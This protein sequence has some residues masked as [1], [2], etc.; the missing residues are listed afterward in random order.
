MNPENHC[1]VKENNFSGAIVRVHVSFRECNPKISPHKFIKPMAS[2]RL[3]RHPS[4]VLGSLCQDFLQ[5]GLV[6]FSPSGPSQS[7]EKDCRVL[8]N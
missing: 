5:T 7:E 3:N 6:G 4:K 1:P 2:S 8:A